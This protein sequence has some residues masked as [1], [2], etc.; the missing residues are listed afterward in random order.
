MPRSRIARATTS[1][2]ASSSVKRSPRSSSE[3]RPLA[4]ERLATGAGRCSRARSDGTGRTRGRPAPR[5]PGTRAATPSP[6]E[7]E[8]FVV[9]SQSAAMPPVA[10]TVA[11]AATA[12]SVGDDADAALVVLPE[13]PDPPPRAGSRCRGCASARS[14]SARAIARRS[15]PRRHGRFDA[16]SGRPRG[17][18]PR[19]TRRPRRQVDDPR[20]RLLGQDAHGARAAQAPAG[21]ERVL[22]VQSGGVVRPDR[23]RDAALRE[24]A[25]RR[26]DGPLRDDARRAPRP[27]RERRGQTGDAGSDDDDVVR[28]ILHQSRPAW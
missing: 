16:A 22:L 24:P 4:A 11:G 5:R 8:G 18:A 20:G 23:G 19:R 26:E 27:P 7:L 3:E 21:A 9:R 17:R 6:T 1:R 15:R 2:G 25:R 14:A 13:G 12:P 10:S 28:A